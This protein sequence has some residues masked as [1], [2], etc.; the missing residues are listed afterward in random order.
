MHCTFRGAN[1]RLATTQR[2]TEGALCGGIR[3]GGVLRRAGV[4]TNGSRLAALQL[5]TKQRKPEAQSLGA[6]AWGWGDTRMAPDL[7]AMEFY[8]L[9]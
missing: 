6:V 8:V 1:W 7:S 5:W 4:S 9:K 2:R 3:E